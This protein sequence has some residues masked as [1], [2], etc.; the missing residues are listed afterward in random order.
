MIPQRL[1]GHGPVLFVHAHPD[2][3][4][5]STGAT[6]AHLA[7]KRCPVTLVTCTR[8][9]RGEVIGSEL[10]H[11]EGDGEALAAHR[12][13]E[14]AAAMAA[15]GVSDHRFLGA[16][17]GVRYQDSGMAWG[18]DGLAKV[19]DDVP[20]DAFALADLDEVA[21]QLAR[22]IEDVRPQYVIS[23][24]P[25]GGY[26]HPDH[27]RASAVSRRAVEL[28]RHS[29]ELLWIVTPRSVSQTDQTRLRQAGL[30]T[31]ELDDAEPSVV[32]DDDLVDFVTHGSARD[33]AAK[34]AGLRAHGTQ[35]IV[36]DDEEA[37]ALSNLIW[38][39][40]SATEY[41]SRARHPAPVE[42]LAEPSAVAGE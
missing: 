23:Y 14:L 25:G 33:H 31:R 39:P 35:V 5:I 21:G 13:Q 38:Q 37:F 11:L 20:A 1:K 29:T 9:E 15:L 3:E 22:I 36:S 26:G 24:D 28:A 7:A 30:T 17:E 41:F 10:A 2:D 18:A 19:A 40:L 12:T 16:A 4:T 34:A 8:G 42:A 6:M 32:V 27:V